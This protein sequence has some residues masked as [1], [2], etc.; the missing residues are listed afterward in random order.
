M[1][2]LLVSLLALL[3]STLVWAYLLNN[4][5]SMEYAWLM[6]YGILLWGVLDFI[7]VIF[8][9]PYRRSIGK[10]TIPAFIAT[11]SVILLFIIME[12]INRFVKHLG[13]G[14]LTPFVALAA[15]LIAAAVFRERNAA[16]KGYLSFN[17]ALLGLLWAMGAVDKIAMPF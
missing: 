2:S 17:N 16:L 9:E 1:K 8:I 10:L 5:I 3:P 6:A 4:N 13:Y 12:G 7:I 11:I 14:V 15:L